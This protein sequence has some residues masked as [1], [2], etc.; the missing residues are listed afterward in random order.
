MDHTNVRTCR[1]VRTKTC[2]Q[3]ATHATIS[4]PPTGP[5][6]E[7]EVPDEETVNQMIARNEEELQIYQQLDLERRR[8]EAK[9]GAARKPRLIEETELPDWLL[10][11]EAEIDELT[12][13]ED[14]EDLFG[15]GSRARKE[16]DYSDSL[17]DRDWLK[18]IGVRTP[19]RTI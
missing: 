12:A 7:N 4:T 1:A 18:A 17:N 13:E 8:E 6:E 11:D 10:R 9:L 14:K 16:V 19:H 5:Q 3:A 15:R 2:T